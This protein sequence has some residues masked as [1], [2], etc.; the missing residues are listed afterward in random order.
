MSAPLPVLDP[1]VPWWLL[2]AFAL[3]ALGLLAFGLWRRARGILWR[4]VFFALLLLVLAGPSLYREE[5]ARLPDQVL[6]LVDRSAS[7]RLD[8]RPEQTEAAL[9][10]LRERL[11]RLRDV[12]VRVVDVPGDP[13]EGTVLLGAL[14]R[15]LTDV[16]RSRL[17]AVFLIT[18]GR[19]HDAA[20]GVVAL[21]PEVPLHVLLTGRSDERD[22]T[23]V[24][25]AAPSWAVVGERQ[26]LVLRV[27][28]DPPGAFENGAR[29]RVELDGRPVFDATVP[30]GRPVHVPFKPE[31]GG[32]SVLEA[33]VAPV[34]GQLTARNDRRVVMV[35]GVR[36][37]LRVLLI[38]GLPHQGLRVW[39]NLLKAD[40]NVDLVHFTILR[41]PEKMDGTP[42]HELALIAFPT[43]ELFEDRLHEFDLV[44]FDRYVR[45]GLLPL[46]YLDNV[47]RYVEEG[48]AL[49]EAAGP[50][51]ASPASLARTPLAR[52]LP[53]EPSGEVLEVA[54]RPEVTDLGR[55]HP[56]TSDLVPAQGE[57]DWGRWMRLID[58]R[59]REG[60][61]VMTG[62]GGRPL[63]VLRRVGEGRVA[64]LLSDQAWLW[65]R[66]FEG[67]G[68]QARLLRRLVHWLMKEPQ[69]EEERLVAR[70][71]GGGLEIERRS[72]D[73]APAVVKITAPSG[74]VSERT[75]VSG[76]DGIARVLIEADEE[77][78]WKVEDGRHVAWAAP[79][80][81]APRELERVRSTGE[82]LE[83]LVR[84]AGGAVVRVEDGLPELRRVGEGRPATG[85]GWLG[86][87]ERGRHLVLGTSRTPLLPP[88]LA[89]LLLLAAAGLAWWREGRSGPVA[90]RGRM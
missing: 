80:P 22:R 54:Y 70:P 9:A 45:R 5:R 53:A 38:S 62:A 60:E 14:R 51:F 48:G 76:P 30:V 1:L 26:E 81:V 46:I 24:V 75:L 68:P 4:A 40:P 2:A 47:A 13:A 71:A 39:R 42:V 83:P 8:V 11:A 37:R 20:A 65:A 25:E 27:E 49:L 12:E 43:T 72:L 88:W 57:P 52:V 74:K 36:D 89:L 31:R 58:T 63:L 87:R 15:A 61:V 17:S 77:G 84:A 19:V 90:G 10:G 78:L 44:I 21:P 67:G 23:V 79:M 35:N 18:D 50:E 29:L 59:V 56:V 41:P 6:V 85:R 55:R 66:G 3:S 34:P 69:L 64:Q 7:Q 28:D 33:R 32:L 16:D 73:L 86:L 82:V